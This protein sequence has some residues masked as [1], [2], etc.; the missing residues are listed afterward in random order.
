MASLGD[1][2][3]LVSLVSCCATVAWDTRLGQKIGFYQLYHTGII[4][5]MYQ[6]YHTEKLCSNRGICS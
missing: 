2:E 3:L 6:L 4:C 5:V 1:P